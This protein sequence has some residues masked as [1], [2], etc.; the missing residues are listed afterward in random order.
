M[1]PLRRAEKLRPK[2]PPPAPCYFVSDLHLLSSRT[3]GHRYLDII[4]TASA[5]AEHFVLG[6]DIFDFRWARRR[7]L[8]DAF[9]EAA[10]WLGEL[11]SGAPSCRFHF[12]LGNHD[13]HAE[14]LEYL[15]KLAGRIDNFA[16]HDYYMRIGSAVFLHGDVADREM[17]AEMLAAL[18][19]REREHKR[20]GPVANTLYDLFVMSQLHRPLPY[21]RHRPKVVARR[22]L[23]YLNEIGHGPASGVKNVYFGHTHWPLADFRYEGIAFHNGGA[24]IGN[25]RYRV[26]PARID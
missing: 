14:F 25:P 10:G 11:A 19:A 26:L 2:L 21:L 1:G 12:V 24:P 7:T 22:I 16:W 4:R 13:H 20:K 9:V 3:Q 15:D 17:D 18:R 8:H 6:G 23:A 5:G